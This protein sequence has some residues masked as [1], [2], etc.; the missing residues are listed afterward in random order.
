MGTGW[1]IFQVGKMAQQKRPNLM[2]CLI[3]RTH[4]VNSYSALLAFTHTK[5]THAR[6]HT[7]HTKFV[8]VFFS[9]D[10][11]VILLI[12]SHLDTRIGHQK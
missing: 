6:T 8:Y 3:F 11:Y 7:P 5:C 4:K 9:H 2:T 1:D 12:R 10:Y